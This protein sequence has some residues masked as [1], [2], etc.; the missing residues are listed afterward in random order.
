MKE[1][2]KWLHKK[3]KEHIAD[4]GKCKIKVPTRYNDYCEKDDCPKQAQEG[5]D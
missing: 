5:G 1:Y 2:K 4:S 3:C